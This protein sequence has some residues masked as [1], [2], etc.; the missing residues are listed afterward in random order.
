MNP[1]GP[2]EQW[3]RTSLENIRQMKSAAEEI[4]GTG[5]L[6]MEGNQSLT[7]LNVLEV[8][9]LSNEYYVAI[10]GE[11]KAGKSTLL[12]AIV[13]QEVA[14][15]SLLP[16]TAA[17]SIVGARKDMED[18]LDEGDALVEFVSRE[19]WDKIV[20]KANYFISAPPGISDVQRERAKTAL[21]LSEKL[22]GGFLDSIQAIQEVIDKHEFGPPEYSQGDREVP[23]VLSPEKCKRWA[24][25]PANLVGH[26]PVSLPA[27]DIADLK[28]FTRQQSPLSWFV[29]SVRIVV[30]HLLSA[31]DL[32]LVDTPGTNDTA[33]NDERTMSV[34]RNTRTRAFILVLKEN[35]G[36]K[37][38]GKKFL[39]EL[40]LKGANTFDRLIVVINFGFNRE[41]FPTLESANKRLK[42]F[43]QEKLE[44]AIRDLRTE[45]SDRDAEVAEY[46][47]NRLRQDNAYFCVNAKA[48]SGETFTEENEGSRLSRHVRRLWR[49][50]RVNAQTDTG[51]PE[52]R[53]YLERFLSADEAHRGFMASA[54]AWLVA[55]RDAL[56]GLADKEIEIAAQRKDQENEDEIIEILQSELDEEKEK[57]E[58]HME[59]LKVVC[60]AK[61]DKLKA[62]ILS[63]QDLI[64]RIS[65]AVDKSVCECWDSEEV[66]LGKMVMAKVKDKLHLSEFAEDPAIKLLTATLTKYVE[67]IIRSHVDNCLEAYEE[68]LKQA[69]DGAAHDF[70]RSIRRPDLSQATIENEFTRIAGGIAAKMGMG[71]VRG[72]GAAI[73]SA[74]V[75]TTVMVMKTQT[76]WWFWTTTVPFTTAIFDPSTLLVAIVAEIIALRVAEIRGRKQVAEDMCKVFSSHPPDETYK[77]GGILYQM[78]HG[79]ESAGIKGIAR[80]AEKHMQRLLKA[81][82]TTFY[83][84]IAAKEQEIGSRQKKLERSD[85]ESLERVEFF[86]EIR[87]NLTHL[88]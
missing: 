45:K 82:R 60:M 51:F 28:L 5:E 27:V 57:L 14:G 58:Q 22:N 76:V 59:D 62:T 42:P 64:K 41:A 26:P 17:L 67:P 39:R 75:P 29:R 73:A 25:N 74:M 9:I 48:A 47:L 83:E 70:S 3:K 44:E 31:Q 12:N 69:A 38:S 85:Q 4:L 56:I 10:A 61:R 18:A 46:A 16:D 80:E 15:V 20:S 81:T 19:E 79:S 35:E 8:E 52:F 43:V 68:E 33:W 71:L 21:K 7:N 53:D 37:Q 32:Y 66:S 63:D 23:L 87:E 13:G 88:L 77:E 86:N 84:S 40:F 24:F 34:L 1:N 49:H 2:Y 11:V 54:Q 6:A 36:I 50:F 72:T 65:K 55:T 30:E 78:W